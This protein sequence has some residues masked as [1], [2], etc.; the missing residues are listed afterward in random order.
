MWAAPGWES[1][2]LDMRIEVSSEAAR[3]PS[4]PGSLRSVP[5]LVIEVSP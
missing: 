3:L 5:G 1:V 2:P 4:L